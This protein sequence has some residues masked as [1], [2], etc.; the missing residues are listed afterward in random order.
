VVARDG[1]VLVIEEEAPPL[2]PGEVLVRPDFSAISPGT[3]RLII[4]SSRRGLSEV[5][6]YPELGQTW[7][8]IRARPADIDR[9]LPRPPRQDVA[10][11]GYGVAGEVIEVAADVDDI[12]VGDRVACAGSQ[13]SFHAEVVAVPR[14]LVV[15]VPAGL[16]LDQ[17]ALVTLGAVSVFGLQR[18]GCSFGESV[19]VYGAGVLG[20]LTIQL[21]R[22]A[23]MT[24]VCID[25][26]EA[27]LSFAARCGAV[28]GSSATDPA[29]VR[30]IDAATDGF[31]VD[32]AVIAVT[33]HADDVIDSALGLL[34]RG[35]TIVLV[36]QLGVHLDRDRLFGARATIVTSS[37]YGPGRY[38]P[39]YEEG[40]VDY[41]IDIVRWTENR[42]MAMFLRFAAEG[43]IDLA[44]IPVARVPIAE[45]PLAYEAIARPDG[46]LTGLLVYGTGV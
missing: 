36:G 43:R 41:P 44:S 4:D 45:A 20:V 16:G 40:N 37:A 39:V 15:P 24:V 21:A 12:A 8:R 7:P 18:A 2:R 31:G 26:N 30:A 27:R 10:S 13:C 6:E 19:A 25:P 11:L 34:R 32:A 33:T 28:T 9:R 14:N 22:A 5:H 46:P 29:L 38:D 1:A 17:A 42:N 35:G 23:G 3:E